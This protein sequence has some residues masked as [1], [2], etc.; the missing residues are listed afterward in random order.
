MDTPKHEWEHVANDPHVERLRVVGGW[1]YLA[2]A[3]M[4]TSPVF[5]PDVP[6]RGPVTIHGFTT[7]YQGPHGV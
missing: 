3:G 2:E 4:G 7:G 6:F 1:L 5:V